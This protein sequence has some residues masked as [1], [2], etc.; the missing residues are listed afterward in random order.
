MQFLNS[1]ISK[2]IHLWRKILNLPLTLW[3]NL[4]Y[5]NRSVDCI[6]TV[7]RLQKPLKPYSPALCGGYFLHI[8]TVKIPIWFHILQ[9]FCVF[10]SHS[11]PPFKTLNNFG[12]ILFRRIPVIVPKTIVKNP[13]S[14]NCTR[15]RIP[16]KG[17]I[18]WEILL[19]DVPRNGV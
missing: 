16:C 12:Q 14:K 3:Q 13:A 19:I 10:H 8:M 7:V 18:F 2:T 17:I 11:L 15:Q 1:S 6:H 9:S 4:I 5:L